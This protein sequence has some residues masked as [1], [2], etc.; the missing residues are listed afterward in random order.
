MLSKHVHKYQAIL[1]ESAGTLIKVSVL[2]AHE[3]RKW[4]LGKNRIHQK[5]GQETG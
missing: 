5:K 2:R 4:F 1:R 3:S